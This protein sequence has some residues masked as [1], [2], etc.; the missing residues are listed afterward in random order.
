MKSP[1]EERIMQLFAAH[2]ILPRSEIYFMEY[3]NQLDSFAIKEVYRTGLNRRALTSN[4]GNIT[5]GIFYDIR[6]TSITS[7]RRQNLQGILLRASMVVTNNDTL[8]HL[9]DYK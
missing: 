8:N 2:P 6:N 7:R 4:I 5:S 9:T 3:K 1:M